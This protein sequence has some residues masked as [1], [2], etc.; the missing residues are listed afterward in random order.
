[1]EKGK[2]VYR[3]VLVFLLVVTSTIIISQSNLKFTGFVVDGENE[4]VN[5]TAVNETINETTETIVNE[6]VTNETVINETTTSDSLINETV[7]NETSTNS[8]ISNET[9]ELLSTNSQE[10]VSCEE[11]WN[12]TI[13][14][15]CDEG[16]KT[17]TCEDLNSCHTSLDKPDEIKTCTVVIQETTEEVITE[18]VEETTQE[19]QPEVTTPTCTPQWKCGD[20]QECKN[21]SQARI[22]IDLNSC[23]IQDSNYPTS[24][25][26]VSILEETCFDKIKNQQ[27][28]GVDCGGQCKKCGFFTM[29]GNVISGQDAGEGSLLKSLFGTTGSTVTTFAVIIAVIVAASFITSFLKMKKP[30]KISQ[31][32]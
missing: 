7:T 9:L 15:E 10:T 22:C 32:K 5:E 23:N 29:M 1:M 11:D 16:N 26:C 3:F 18:T 21:N 12:C 25:V 28:I 31:K 4:T 30:A 8:T 17:R 19:T 20:W 13:W 2:L 14:S 24:Q 6:T 27:E